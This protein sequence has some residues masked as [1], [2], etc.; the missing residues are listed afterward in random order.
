MQQLY[1]CDETDD[2][3]EPKKEGGLKHKDSLKCQMTDQLEALKRVKSHLETEG[4]QEE[5]MAEKAA[6]KD[7]KKP[8]KSKIALM[9]EKKLYEKF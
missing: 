2:S 9:L 5:T 6:K 4:I 7:Q 1:K 8:T 3:P